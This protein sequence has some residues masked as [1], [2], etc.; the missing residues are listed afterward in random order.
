VGDVLSYFNELTKAMTL[1]SDKGA[2]FLGQSIAYD[3]QAMHTSFS[4]VPIEKRIEMPV[5]EDFQM[6]YCTGLAI[7]GVLPVCVYPRFDFLLL[8]ANQLIT[9]LDKLPIMSKYKPKVIIRTAVGSTKPLNPG[10]QHCNDYTSAF[11]SML[12]SINV[13]RLHYEEQIVPSYQRAIESP[14]ST[15][16]VEYA[17]EYRR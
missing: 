13:V 17:S 1:L 9:H 10:P 8:A 12:V 2:I 5:A 3:G 16:L 7:A 15:L 11:E 6:G 4:G 14:R